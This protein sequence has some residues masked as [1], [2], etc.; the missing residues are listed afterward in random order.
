MNPD[1][2]QL[3]AYPF[4]KL[5]QLKANCSPPDNLAHIP[6]SIGE[7]KHPAPDFVLES[8]AENLSGIS[9]YPVTKGL[10]SLRETI[11]SWLATRLKIKPD[12]KSVV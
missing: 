5:A 7:P 1:L 10:L 11:A 6:L 9:S 3:H 12:R 4:E 2:S 8:L